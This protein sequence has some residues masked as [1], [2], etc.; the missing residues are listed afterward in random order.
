META[1]LDGLE[2]DACAAC[3]EVVV[4]EMLMLQPFTWD[5]EPTDS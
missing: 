2:L 1:G 3:S 5:I 4:S